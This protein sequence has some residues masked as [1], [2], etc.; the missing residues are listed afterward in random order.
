MAPRPGMDLKV[1]YCKLDKSLYGLKQLP[2]IGTKIS[3]STLSQLV[4]SSAF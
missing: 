4:S 1:G 3:L 2:E